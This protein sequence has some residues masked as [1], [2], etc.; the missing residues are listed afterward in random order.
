MGLKKAMEV[1]LKNYRRP[2][3]DK[4]GFAPASVTWVDNED[5]CCVLRL[6]ANGDM[7]S[8]EQGPEGIVDNYVTRLSFKERHKLLKAL[9]KPD[10]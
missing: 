2:Q 5:R 4:G 9:E 10:E 1:S 8:S 7:L 6:F 3:Y